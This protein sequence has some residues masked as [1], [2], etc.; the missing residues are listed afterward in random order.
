MTG[1]FVKSKSILLSWGFGHS[2]LYSVLTSTSG[3]II[4]AVIYPTIAAAKLQ[5][6]DSWEKVGK[7]TLDWVSR[8]KYLVAQDEAGYFLL[9][10]LL[11]YCILIIIYRP[12]L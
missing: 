9:L 7:N 8:V 11:L 3:V 4:T 6:V 10:L 5:G 2:R 12:L 1:Y